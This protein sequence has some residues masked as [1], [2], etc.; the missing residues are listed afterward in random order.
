MLYPY[1]TR[2]REVKDLSGIWKFK[3]DKHNQGQ[4]EKWYEKPLVDPILMPVPASYNDITQEAAI[5]DHIGDVWYETTT[6]VPMSWK[7]KRV[8]LRFGSV[9]HYG[10]VWINGKHIVE[11][12]GGYLPFEAEISEYIILGEEARITVRV[13]NELD[14]QTL[15]PGE[16]VYLED[17]YRYPEPIKFQKYFHDFFNYAGIHRPVKLYTTPANYISDITTDTNV[18]GTTG[19]IKYDIKCQG[20]GSLQ[21]K[22]LDTKGSV[23][24]TSVGASGEIKIENVTLWKPLK[25]YLY[26]FVV[27][28]AD[29]DEDEY[30]LKIGIRTVEVKDDQFLINNE[31]FYFKGFGKH[32]DMNIKG[33]GLDH[34][35]NIK[36]F[37]LMQW[38]GANS[39]RTSHYPYSEEILDLADEYGIVVINESPAVGMTFFNESKPAFME[40]KINN[41]TK[42]H[43]IEIM[44]ELIQRDKNH[45]CVVMW[46]VA[47]EPASWEDNARPYFKDVIDATRRFDPTRPI[48]MVSY[49]FPYGERTCQ[50][51]DM[52]DVICINKYYS[53]YE[54]S[55][56]LD[57]VEYQVEKEL[58]LWHEKFKKP[59]IM[60][61]YGADSI[62]GFHSNPAVMF[63]EEYQIEMIQKFNKV[64]DK[65]DYVIGEHIWAFSDFATKQGT[66]RVVGNKKGVFTRDRNPK[67]IAFETK[68][69]WDN[70]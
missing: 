42:E 15:P 9:T 39:F 33:K 6:I 70:K 10:S 40:D 38:I 23:V 55:G 41:K 28:F 63:T 43:H 56:M 52:V 66:T 59:I 7:N 8:V 61:E 2:S 47:N 19:I 18:D 13:N 69:R 53:W 57:L 37:N 26:R 5:R 58:S 65:L 27:S 68:K 36:D 54:D 64:F 50:V 48:T 67:A 62:A 12:K 22:V 21:V 45:P 49:G 35:I 3:F 11:H 29:T 46:S 51:S 32:E 30:I 14:W 60:S 34:V 20:T 31:P 16:I 1:E 17:E 44:D 25:S 4:K 24:G